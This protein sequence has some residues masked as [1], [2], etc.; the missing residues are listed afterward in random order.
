MTK[1]D[2]Y[3]IP[4]PANLSESVRISQQFN[5]GFEYNDFFMPQLLDNETELRAR[6]DL[7]KSLNRLKGRDNLHGVFFDICLNSIDSK[8][9]QISEMR[10]RSSME[11][12][13]ELACKGVIFHTNIIQGFETKSYL[14]GWVE[15]N[16]AFYRKLCREY[17]D[18]N[19]YVENMFDYAPYMLRKLAE[20]MSDVE[21]F[22]VCYDVAHGHVHDISMGEWIQELG[23]YIRHMH[24]NDNDGRV[25]L[26]QPVGSGTINWDSFFELIENVDA[27]AGILIEVNGANK[28]EESLAFLKEKGFLE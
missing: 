10:M 17:S 8:I 20:E 19:I 9:K 3:I 25:D 23:P 1:R 13:S 22:G 27:K 15:A 21:N 5:T 12:A 18:M 26:H 11:I 14:D 2:I 16:A 24:I 7:Y 4:D 28:Q 6:I